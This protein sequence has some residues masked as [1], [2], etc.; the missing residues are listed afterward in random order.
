MQAPLGASGGACVAIKRVLLSW[1][2]TPRLLAGV[3]VADLK[4][5]I[6]RT[7]L[8]YDSARPCAGDMEVN[9]KSSDFVLVLG[10]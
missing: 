3:I 6:F 7:Y 5:G 8:I 1:I 9:M 4:K 2:M 10:E